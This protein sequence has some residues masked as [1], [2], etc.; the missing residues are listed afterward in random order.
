MVC[1]RPC[2][3]SGIEGPCRRPGDW[4]HRIYLGAI[5]DYHKR[6]LE[7]FVRTGW[8]RALYRRWPEWLGFNE[9]ED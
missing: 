3:C 1:Q 7:R 4:V 5:C 6:E 9:W 8:R 2:C